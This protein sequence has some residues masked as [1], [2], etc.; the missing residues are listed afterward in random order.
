VDLLVTDVGLPGMDGRD[1]A[2]RARAQR[3]E[4]PVLFMTGYVEAASKDSWSGPR[5]GLIVKPFTLDVLAVRVRNMLAA[6]APDV[7]ARP[8]A[9]EG[10]AP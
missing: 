6:G 10:G 9:P 2:E 8:L 1:L 4:L 7:S 3:P 5:T